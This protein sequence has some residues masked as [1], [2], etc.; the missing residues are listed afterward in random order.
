[1]YIHVARQR[2]REGHRGRGRRGE[3][4]DGNSKGK[5]SGTWQKVR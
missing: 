1:M 3:N 5:A 4:E 2:Y